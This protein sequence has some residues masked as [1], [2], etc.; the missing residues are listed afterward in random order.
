[1]GGSPA[2]TTDTK[3]Q[4]QSCIKQITLV[5]RELLSS[6]NSMNQVRYDK[7]N[8]YRLTYSRVKKLLSYLI[9]S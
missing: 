9:F 7:D 8:E 1:M 2:S 6:C 5:Q 4:S 3:C